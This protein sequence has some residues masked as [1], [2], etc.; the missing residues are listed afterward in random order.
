MEYLELANT[1]SSQFEELFEHN[2]K[3]IKARSKKKLLKYMLSF[4]RK[5]LYSTLVENAIVSPAFL[6]EALLK[7]NEKYPVI[8]PSPESFDKLAK[9]NFNTLYYSLEEHI[10]IQDLKIMISS[11]MPD[12]EL[13]EYNCLTEEHEL[14]LME[15]LSIKDPFYVEYLLLICINLNIIKKIPSIHSNRAQVSKQYDVLFSKNPKEILSVLIDSAVNIAVSFIN[16]IIPVNNIVDNNYIINLLKN[17]VSTEDIFKAL[18]GSLEPYIKKYMEYNDEDIVDEMYAVIVSSTFHLGIIIDKYFFTPFGFYFKLITPIYLLKHDMHEEMLFALEAINNDDGLNIAMFSPCSSYNLTSL[19][20][21]Y[22][23]VKD[24]FTLKSDTTEVSNDMLLL[25]LK[26]KNYE[27]LTKVFNNSSLTRDDNIVQ[28][29]IALS[30]FKVYWKK[31]EIYDDSYLKSIYS[32]ICDEFGFERNNKYCFY[33]D[34]TENPFSKYSSPELKAKGKSTEHVLLKDLNIKAKDKFILIIY[35]TYSPITNITH[36]SI[37]LELEITKSVQMNKN[38]Y[39]P[40]I[41]NSSAKFK[42]FELDWPFN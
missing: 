12:F 3:S 26:N 38:L 11:F 23:G 8:I 30:D 15:K 2:F 7:D 22:F 42:E 27:F 34:L 5:W 13:D 21:T 16:E 39:Y 6:S 17:P 18:Y 25:N 10:I 35:D 33:T 9:L 41:S 40:R 31:L 28:I 24:S 32:I 19:G 29:K 37:K 1:L 4:Y 14:M 20:Q 36:K